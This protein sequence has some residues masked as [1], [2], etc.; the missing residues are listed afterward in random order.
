MSEISLEVTVH[1][2]ED[3]EANMADNT[4]G[5]KAGINSEEIST[6]WPK[7]KPGTRNQDVDR[8]QEI[9]SVPP[10]DNEHTDND[11]EEDEGR[12]SGLLPLGTSDLDIRDD[13]R[14]SG[15][16]DIDDISE[17]DELQGMVSDDVAKAVALSLSK[18]VNRSTLDGAWSI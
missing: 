5:V 8:T 6:S 18:V 2:A 1:A 17:E 3:T 4:E 9:I 14:D 12:F 10:S 13:W 16:E 7:S 15:A 11:G